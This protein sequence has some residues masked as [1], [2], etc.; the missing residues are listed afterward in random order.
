MNTIDRYLA[1]AVLL[2]IGL[3]L[4]ILVALER[5]I[6]FVGQLDDINDDGYR[7]QELL[8][9]IA[10]HIPGSIYEMMATA[11][12]L[13]ALLG[14]GGLAK[15]SELIIVRTAGMSLARIARPLII[16]GTGLAIA[17]FSMGEWLLPKSEEYASR[18]RLM[19]LSREM[20]IQG[21][22][23]LWLREGNRFINV[24]RIFPGFNLRGVSVYEYE[25][26]TLVKLVRAGSASYD[27]K[28]GW[29]LKQVETSRF[30]RGEL[31]LDQSASQQQASLLNPEMLRGLS[32]QPEMLSASELYENVRYLK[33]NQLQS[34]A[35]ELAFWS[36][37]SVPASTIVMFLIALPFVLGSQRLASGGK[38]I[39][40]GSLIGIGFLLL[41]R[42]SSHLGLVIGAHGAI[43][44]FFPIALLT[45]VGLLAIR[46]ID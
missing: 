13:G 27:K 36:K 12:V 35:Y 37:F 30:N 11:T 17:M 20:S 14:L 32:L 25:G 1:R 31:I 5:L 21:R 3:V 38:R 10:L 4:M 18:L 29:H 45:V 9:N 40:I 33:D 42:V 41:S 24:R 15:N 26:N 43:G 16:V 46:R 2:S 22:S 23:G 6:A 34:A 7:I 44:A 39:F 8:T 28:S 19:A